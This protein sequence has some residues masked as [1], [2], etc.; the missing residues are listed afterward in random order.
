MR[1]GPRKILEK[2]SARAE[3]KSEITVWGVRQ[4]V[5]LSPGGGAR[6]FIG[7]RHVLGVSLTHMAVWYWLFRTLTEL[8]FTDWKCMSD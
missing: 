6:V 5:G 7:W 3:K 1:F 8:S 4:H 2:L